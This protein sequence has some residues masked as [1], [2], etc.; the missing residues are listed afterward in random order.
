MVSLFGSENH[1]GSENQ[2][3]R[4]IWFV[5]THGC[6]Y[7]ISYISSSYMHLH[8]HL[9]C[10]FQSSVSC[11][12]DF[13]PPAWLGPL[14]LKPVPAIGWEAIRSAITEH[15]RTNHEKN[16]KILPASD[17]WLYHVISHI[18][19]LREKSDISGI[20]EI[21]IYAMRPSQGTRMRW[22][23]IPTVSAATAK[24]WLGLCFAMCQQIC[25]ACI[26]DCFSSW[27]NIKIIHQLQSQLSHK[28]Y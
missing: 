1:F 28:L 16:T 7:H 4:W 2:N 26:I 5:Y 11:P 25:Q 12:R 9:Q 18:L 3:L 27:T 24:K 21:M 22:G 13:R 10:F 19:G 23:L 14:A 8:V 20:F 17:F 6:F 15:S